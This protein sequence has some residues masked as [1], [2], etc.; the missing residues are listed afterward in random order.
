[1]PVVRLRARRRGAPGERGL[2]TAGPGDA[3]RPALES[4]WLLARAGLAL[5]PPVD[6]PKALRPLLAHAKLTTA[7]LRTIQRV[8]DED[9]EFRSR[10]A[11][12]VDEEGVGRAGWLFLTRPEGW[13]DE[14]DRLADQAAEAAGAAAEERDERLARRRL[15][16]AEEARQRAEQAA[17]DLRSQVARVNAE[18][19]AERQARQEAERGTAR[20]RQSVERLE[21]ER[22]D[23]R[24]AAASAGSLR[25]QV[26]DLE[27]DVARL[28][29][30]ADKAAEALGAAVAA[31]AAAESMERASRAQPVEDDAPM[32]AEPGLDVAAV[33]RAVADAARAAVELGQ[34]LGTAA[35]RLGVVWP[36]EGEGDPAVEAGRSPPADATPMQRPPPPARPPRRVPVRLP[37]AVFDDSVEAAEH[38]VRTG[39]VVVLVDGYNASLAYR[40]DLPIAELRA[41]FTDAL[42]EL[43]ARTGADI[44][45]VFDGAEQATPPA[46]A[47]ARRA[48]RVTF[49]PPDV[50]ADDVI[51]SLIDTVPLQRPVVV[52]SSDRRVQA[53]ALQRGANVISS[54]Q[55][56]AILR[57]GD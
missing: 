20:L 42:T 23:A 31:D 37:P 13:Q 52:A 53:G 34:A 55:L 48:V 28:T 24:T 36:A 46:G 11:E 51:L 50:E 9:G 40:S 2:T 4:A 32:A 25:N 1:M 8:L 12:V 19:T 49:S 10:V 57:R 21:G 14:V 15:K 33:A 45:V 22:D 35:S 26:R 47:P 29:A 5:Q 41:R 44:H 54:Q 18:L 38:L 6:P 39:G 3:L 16:G 56:L 30:E 43:A 17:A 27:A 7:A